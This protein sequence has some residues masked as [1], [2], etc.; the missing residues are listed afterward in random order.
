VQGGLRERGAEPP[1]LPG[2]GPL[3]FG[4]PAGDPAPL[5][6]AKLCFLLSATERF[7][8]QGR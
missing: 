7:L 1:R 6:E 4:F 8:L 3:A 5:R 2:I